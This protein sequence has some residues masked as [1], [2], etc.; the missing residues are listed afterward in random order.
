MAAHDASELDPAAEVSPVMMSSPKTAEGPVESCDEEDRPREL[1]MK[2]R[3]S[4]NSGLREVV[5]DNDNIIVA[6][7]KSERRMTFISV[8]ATHQESLFLL[9]RLNPTC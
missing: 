3:A 4:L 2:E 6:N 5:S 9:T 7:N 1:G 8:L